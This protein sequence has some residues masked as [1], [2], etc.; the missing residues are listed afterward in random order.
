MN[1][2]LAERFIF[3]V[4]TGRCGQSSLTELV[5]NHV[6]DCYPAFEEPNIKPVLPAPFNTY[7]RRF[8]RRFVETNELLG[9]GK[10]LTAYEVG[11]YGYIRMIASKRL[12]MIRRAL[13]NTNSSIYFDISK[14]FARGL[15]S[16]FLLSVRNI[17]LVNLVR[18]PL[19]NMKSFTNRAKNFRLDNSM[20]DACSNILRLDPAG[21]EP[22]ELYLWAWCELY[23]RYEEMRQRPGVTHAVEIRTEHLTDAAKMN[24]TLDALGLDHSPV[25]PR[26]ARNTNSEQGLPETKVTEQDIALFERFLSR[27]P[28]LMLD[29]IAYL[30]DY[31]PRAFHMTDKTRSHAPAFS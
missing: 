19:R 13:A 28:S 8:R 24:A 10:V 21:M 31:D 22:G 6:P 26:P 16:G 17:A 20:P 2:P 29:R 27:V 5:E 11:D 1:A 30:K 25:Q 9:R 3:T 15:H 12:R 23:L 4:A 14:F 7:E 18:D